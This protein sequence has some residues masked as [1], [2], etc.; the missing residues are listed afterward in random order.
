MKDTQTE[1]QYF[2]NSNK[3]DGWSIRVGMTGLPAF[4]QSEFWDVYLGIALDKIE[5][6]IYWQASAYDDQTDF[7]IVKFSSDLCQDN[8]GAKTVH[9]GQEFGYFNQHIPYNFPY[10]SD[11][12][13]YADRY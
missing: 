6:K 12:V 2:V 13:W 3:Y 9:E 11:Q 5:S 4:Q 7:K 8:C 10:G 1:E